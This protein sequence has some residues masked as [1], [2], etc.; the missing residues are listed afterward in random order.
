MP[1]VRQYTRQVETNPLPAVRK[2]E[3]AIP[4]LETPAPRVAE[5]GTQEGIERFSQTIAR[6]AAEL[7]EKEQTKQDQMRLL[8]A[9]KDMGDLE[10]QLLYDDGGAF[11]VYGAASYGLPDSVSKAWDEGSDKIRKGLN[12]DKQ[13]IAFDEY[14]TQQKDR[15]LN[16]VY[17]HV[18]QQRRQ[19]DK[20][21]VEGIVENETNAAL[22]NPGPDDQRLARAEQSVAAINAAY[23]IWAQHYGIP[24]QELQAG[25]A[26][27]ASRIY[28]G[29]ING[30]LDKGQD[31]KAKAYA[32]HHEKDL[33][34]EDRRILARVSAESSLGESQRYGDTITGGGA[35]GMVDPPT[36]TPKQIYER[37]I[38]DNDTGE[39]LPPG[40]DV[41]GRRSYSTTVSE[42]DQDPR[43]GKEV[44]YPTVIDGKK[45]TR[46]E[47]WEHY[48]KTG[49][50]LGKFDTPENAELYATQLHNRQDRYARGEDNGPTEDEMM[51]QAKLIKDATVRQRT[52]E[53]IG[54]YWIRKRQQIRFEEEN[55]AK[56]AKA[57]LDQLETGLKNRLDAAQRTL[58]F[59]QI[60]PSSIREKLPESTEKALREY[61]KMISEEKAVKT[62]PKRYY[63]LSQMASLDPD[64][65]L[66][67]NLY[68]DINKLSTGAWE[69]MVKLQNAI[70]NR[71]MDEAAKLTEGFRG[72]NEMI[73]DRYGR[74][75]GHEPKDTVP[76]EYNV[77]VA[78]HDAVDQ[79]IIDYENAHKGEKNPK[80]SH[81][82]ILE[83]IDKHLTKGFITTPGLLWGTNQTET[84]EVQAPKGSN[85]SIQIQHVPA[86]DRAEIEKQLR[87]NH[88]PVSD[89]NILGLYLAQVRREKFVPEAT[90]PSKTPMRLP[91]PQS[92]PP[93]G[94]KRTT[95]PSDKEMNEFIRQ[96]QQEELE[97]TLRNGPIK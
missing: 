6:G 89:A 80:P 86:K 14:N 55:A 38:L 60:I 97:N 21:I 42:S 34:L 47:A 71:K 75:L 79:D 22:S 56:Q 10:R 13:R 66:Q 31:L 78:L 61:W 45:L 30:Y 70:R 52:E 49:E 73:K 16:G 36:L 63:E 35:I 29:M 4:H 53:R 62:D 59:D 40:S 85:F 77:I 1:Q 27:A 64:K 74:I 33:V 95:K 50:H 2:Q 9:H 93:A 83:F 94:L 51:E 20:G 84:L 17:S 12:N 72:V 76:A 54:Q 81:E 24:A 82:Q 91:A 87:A 69:D 41:S 15:I 67:Q 57:A 39:I 37:P 18:D 26:K 58:S 90:K 3:Y 43:D 96:Q 44:V 5:T 48:L 25:K 32:E 19:V 68:G 28:A 92:K 8:Q 11:H 65:F 23:D 7:W 88:Y 46:E